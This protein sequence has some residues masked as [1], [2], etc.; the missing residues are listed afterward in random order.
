MGIIEIRQAKHEEN[1]IKEML[2][3]FFRILIKTIKV[4]MLS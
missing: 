3:N 2:T 4:T 1:K